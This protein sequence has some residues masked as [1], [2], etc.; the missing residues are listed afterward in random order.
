MPKV[1][2]VKSQVG[3]ASTAKFQGDIQFSWLFC[4]ATGRSKKNKHSEECRVEYPSEPCKEG[5]ADMVQK[6]AQEGAG[7]LVMMAGCPY[8]CV[9]HLGG[10]DKTGSCVQGK[11][12]VGKVHTGRF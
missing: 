8:N 6:G 4:W 11:E 3:Q 7:S 9:L 10:M 2:L 12:K 5:G 1:T